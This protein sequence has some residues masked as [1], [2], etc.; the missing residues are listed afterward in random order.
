MGA[1]AGPA[2]LRTARVSSGSA[3]LGPGGP[4]RGYCCPPGGAWVRPA[5]ESQPAAPRASALSSGA[6]R[7]VDPGL[8]PG[9]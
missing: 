8:A 4:E 1:G 6:F 2:R 9:R 3:P 7:L 5:R